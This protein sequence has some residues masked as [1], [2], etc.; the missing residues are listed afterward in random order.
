M[1]VQLL[2][3][4]ALALLARGARP[5]TSAT[6]RDILANLLTLWFF[7]TPIIYPWFQPRCRASAALFDLNPFTHIVVSYQEIL[8]FTTV[9]S[10]TGS[11]C[12]RS[13]P[14]R[15]CSSQVW[16]SIACAFVAEAVTCAV[17]PARAII[18]CAG[19]RC[20]AR[21]NAIELDVE[22]HRKIYRRYGGRQFSTLKSALLQRSI[23]RDLQ[24][25][26]TFPAL[27]DVSFTSRRAPPSA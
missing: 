1:L 9:R 16:L 13:A 5:C 10:A 12:W 20:D 25:S 14:A 18:A 27:T 3:T 15:C 11:G 17:R 4:L 2:F 19:G 23:L 22:R 26:E 6:S 21:R 24:P 7:A 8:F